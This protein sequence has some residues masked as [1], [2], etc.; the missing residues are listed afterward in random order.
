[1][2]QTQTLEKLQQMRLFGMQ[3]AWQT[4]LESN[5]SYTND[6]L[7][8]YLVEAEWDDRQNRKVNR[9]LKAARFRYQASIEE[10]DFQ[11]PRN[12]DQNLFLRLADTSFIQKH[13]VV[14]IT[15]PTGSGKSFLASALGNQACSRGYRTKYFS[16][17]KLFQKLAMARADRSHLKLFDTI[18]RTDLLILDDFGLW[19]LNKQARL[20]L[21]EIIEDRHG[22]KATII[23]SQ[24][25]VK[26][27]FDI[28]EDKTIADAILDRI[29]HQAHRIK[30]T[31]ESLR[32]K[33]N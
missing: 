7:I 30:L 23:A 18:E 12:L 5:S 28:I 19:P 16:T 11:S 31:G 1:M 3:N 32:K 17:G 22:K 27:W 2:S 8:N 26:E 13:Q 33:K 14:I 15:G 21:L 20:D 10:I 9:Y 29:I 24:I 6:Q 4:A 25:P